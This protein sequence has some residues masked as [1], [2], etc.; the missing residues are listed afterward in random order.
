MNDYSLK[1]KKTTRKAL[2]LKLN[3]NQKYTT[4]LVNAIIGNNTGNNIDE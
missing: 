1:K 4:K 3:L 2:Q